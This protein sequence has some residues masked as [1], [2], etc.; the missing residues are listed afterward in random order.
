MNQNFDLVGFL[1]SK[2]AKTT[3][4]GIS[5]TQLISRYQ[6]FAIIMINLFFLSVLL[7]WKIIDLLIIRLPGD[8]VI[9]FLTPI[10]IASLVM[11]KMGRKD[12]AAVF[13][14]FAIHLGNFIAS[15][16]CDM[17]LGAAY[18]VVLLP[19]LAYF[20]SSSKRVYFMNIVLCLAQNAGHIIRINHT[21]RITFTEDQQF[22]VFT[23]GIVSFMYI[24]LSWILF[25][26][27]KFIE[28]SLLEVAYLN[29]EKAENI[30]K[31]LVETVDA[32][33][34]VVSNF[35]HEVRNPLNALNGCIEYLLKVAKT[36]S[37]IKVLQNA[38]LSGSVL[39]NLVNNVLDAAKLR[40]DKLDI[41][42]TG[43]DPSDIVKRALDIN[44]EILKEKG[45]NAKLYLQKNLP[46]KVFA[47]SS[48][49]LQVLLNLLSNAIKFTKPRGEI[50]ITEGWS[51][52]HED[53]EDLLVPKRTSSDLVLE[54]EVQGN[55]DSLS[56]SLAL[57][58]EFDEF[59]ATESV[60]HSRR[61]SDV[62][63]VLEKFSLKDIGRENSRLNLSTTDRSHLVHQPSR[64]GR[65]E[66]DAT[67]SHSKGY[68]K[69]EISDTGCGIAPENIS[70]L[71]NMFSQ[72]EGSQ[73]NLDA[74]GTGLG[75]WI[76]RQL[77]QKM[78]GDIK[79]Y[80]NPNEGTKV[81]FY[82]RVNNT[83]L[84]LT[85]SRISS[86]KLRALVVDDYAYNRDVH[87]LIVEREGVEVFTACDG[88]EAL[89]KY[90][91]SGEGYF[92]F[93]MMDIQMPEMDGLTSAKEMRKFDKES[94]RTSSD[95][96]FVSG[97]YYSK[98]DALVGQRDELQNTQFLRKPIDVGMLKQ[99]IDKY[100]NPLGGGRV[101]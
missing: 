38:K 17:Q 85:T 81:I 51:S 79:L 65:T 64:R 61:M 30:T 54:T 57:D 62:K 46:N 31:E 82:V 66:S 55:D 70:K 91:A 15:K 75:L 98:N 72:V 71:F 53:K 50:K 28:T 99:I 93:I 80:S 20:V 101:V 49:I 83:A 3:P 36:P 45:I 42:Y 59:L 39:L 41:V 86:G 89:E 92:T 26:I 78:G 68:L 29:Y 12:T 16:V 34:K 11:L 14:I 100:K 60:E 22:Q 32:K 18:L 74:G 24:I 23:L 52:Y 9:I 73:M 37:E 33:D 94:G 95:I 96:Y 8:E 88:K 25:G 19:G 4:H 48:R 67:S 77:C 40:A 21:F 97:N 44:T 2:F 43:C 27:Q 6:S 47:D 58:T 7:L 1:L 56:R 63:G 87:K 76:C 90:Q 10:Q 35:S 5:V 69:F 84:P 13:L